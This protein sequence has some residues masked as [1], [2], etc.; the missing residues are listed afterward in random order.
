MSLTNLRRWVFVF[1]Q[2][3]SPPNSSSTGHVG[4]TVAHVSRQRLGSSTVIASAPPLP[5]DSVGVG[6]ASG[7][8]TNTV[9]DAA[10]PVPRPPIGRW[11]DPPPVPRP[12]IVGPSV[13]VAAPVQVPDHD[14]S[15]G[16]P[17]A[18]TG[19]HGKPQIVRP[20]R[21]VTARPNQRPGRGAPVPPTT[22][23]VS[24]PVVVDWSMI[25]EL[26]TATPEQRH[27]ILGRCRC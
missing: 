8:G 11:L 17:N 22:V 4:S 12:T 23:P 9:S 15:H 14:I 13:G 10:V 16:G 18:A 20:V 7:P 5:A 24:G 19:P 25:H 2:P 6:H 1:P 21:V 26:S 27:S 3:P